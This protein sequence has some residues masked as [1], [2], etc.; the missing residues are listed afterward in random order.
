M[1]KIDQIKFLLG[2]DNHLLHL[3]MEID[4]L[5]FYQD[6]VIDVSSGLMWPKNANMFGPYIQFEEA[7]ETISKLTLAGHTDW[8]FPTED[9]LLLFIKDRQSAVE[10]CKTCAPISHA[11][12]NG[13][14]STNYWVSEGDDYGHVH[15]SSGKTGDNHSNCCLWPVR[16]GKTQEQRDIEKQLKIQNE[17]LERLKEVEVCQLINPDVYTADKVEQVKSLI[18][19]TKYLSDPL[20]PGKVV[21]GLLFY[22]DVVIDVSSGLM[23]ARNS[24]LHGELIQ[25]ID[26]KKAISKLSLAGHTDWRFPTEDEVLT[27]IDDRNSTEQIGMS[28]NIFSHAGFNR[29]KPSRYWVREGDCHG[30]VDTSSRITGDNYMYCY[31]WI[32]RDG[33]TQEQRVI[34]KQQ[35]IQKRKQRMG[36]RR[37][38]K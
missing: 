9:E 20:T 4:T 24:A 35:K 38:R 22:K 8:R 17:K 14:L 23:W 32:V 13:A 18:C 5:L 26:A 12:F 15:L 31:L 36:S 21:D 28:G 10:N 33:K 2:E 7:K 37:A 11:G 19:D 3:E 34:E 25:F 27:F 29:M 6:V 30:H 16:D 1:D